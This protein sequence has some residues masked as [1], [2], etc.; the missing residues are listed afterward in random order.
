MIPALGMVI[1]PRILVLRMGMFQAA[2]AF[3]AWLAS[4]ESYSH[5]WGM[6]RYGGM[7]YHGWG[8]ML[9][10]SRT[11]ATTATQNALTFLGETHARFNRFQ[12]LGSNLTP[13]SVSKPIAINRQAGGNA[14]RNI[15][16]T[17]G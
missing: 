13:L 8:G 14:S 7:A 5:R 12:N 16:F 9:A 6:V 11:A 4:Y 10:R 3:L 15:T 1:L 17:R 2:V